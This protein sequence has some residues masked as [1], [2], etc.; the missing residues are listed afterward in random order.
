MDKIWVRVINQNC[1][2]YIYK[3]SEK[4]TL[5]KPIRITTMDI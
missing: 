3:I 4:V 2:I 5:G 1:L